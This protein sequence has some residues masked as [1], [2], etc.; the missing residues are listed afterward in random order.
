MNQ[1]KDVVI[2]TGS[3]GDIGP[4]LIHKFAERYRLVGFAVVIPTGD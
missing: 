4:A 3:S 1:G 2:V